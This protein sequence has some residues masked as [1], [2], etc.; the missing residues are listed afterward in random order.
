MNRNGPGL[1]ADLDRDVADQLPPLLSSTAKP[2]SAALISWRRSPLAWRSS[3]RRAL[4]GGHD[5]DL[6]LLWA[7]DKDLYAL[8]RDSE[9]PDGEAVAGEGDTPEVGAVLTRMGTDMPHLP[10]PAFHV[11]NLTSMSNYLLTSKMARPILRRIWLNTWRTK[12]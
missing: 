12:A 5:F 4:H 10:V 6:T 11:A 3:T 9:R 2:R 7:T 8:L 1:R